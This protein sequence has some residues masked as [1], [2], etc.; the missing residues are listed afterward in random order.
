MLLDARL[1]NPLDLIRG[2][3]HRGL[4]AEDRHERL[5]L[6]RLRVDRVDGGGHGCEGTGEDGDGLADLVVVRQ[7]RLC[8]L[9]TSDAADE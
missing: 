6:A 7:L 2:E 5:D 9:Y 4:A 8:L 1:N 3:L